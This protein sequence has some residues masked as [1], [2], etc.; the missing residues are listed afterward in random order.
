MDLLAGGRDLEGQG[1]EIALTFRYCVTH[2]MRDT[3]EVNGGSSNRYIRK[4][5]PRAAPRLPR[6]GGPGRAGERAL[7]IHAAQSA[8]G[9]WTLG[10][11]GDALPAASPARGAGASGQHVARGR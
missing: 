10:R 3:G 9:A 7:R 6:P 1:P 5:A 2:T 11:R 8:R 4:P